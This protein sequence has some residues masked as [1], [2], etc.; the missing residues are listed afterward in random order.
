LHNFEIFVQRTSSP[1]AFSIGRVRVG[2]DRS[3]S[4]V[5]RQ[6]VRGLT[7]P[8]IGGRKCRRWGGAVSARRRTD[9]ACEKR[10]CDAHALYILRAVA[11][12]LLLL[13][14]LLAA[15]AALLIDQCLDVENRSAHAPKRRRC[16]SVP[17]PRCWRERERER[18]CRIRLL[19]NR[20]DGFSLAACALPATKTCRLRGVVRS[21]ALSL[22][23]LQVNLW[24][25]RT[26]VL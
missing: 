1:A 21:A 10:C 5:A 6:K 20:L 4:G 22:F 16:E 3:V 2:V 26:H 15:A 23:R 24:S 8:A 14:L 11:A 7:W 18:C 17:P 25:G 12:R 19:P 9:S 13:L